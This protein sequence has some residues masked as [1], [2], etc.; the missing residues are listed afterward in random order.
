MS[1]PHLEVAVG[2]ILR[3]D[4]HVL[5]GS[6]PAGKPWEG[7]WEL[8]G[9]KIEAGETVL[10]ALA[11]ELKEELDI[12]V[13]HAEPWVIY[14]HEY[15]KNT[16]R[17][18]FYRIHNWQGEPRGLEGQEIKWVAPRNP[19]T[20]GPLLPAALPPLRW[21]QLPEQ[22]LLT[23]IG[24]AEQLPLY[25]QKL[26]QALQ[27]GLRM[28]QFR[29]P[30]WA[31]QT[32]QNQAIHAAFQQV[33]S[34]C[35]RYQALCLINSVHPEAWWPQADGL[36]LRSN[37]ASPWQSRFSH[38]VS[39]RQGLLAMSTHNEADIQVARALNTDFIVL[40]HVLDTPSHPNVAGM[41]WQQFEQQQQHAACPVYAIGGQSAST[42]AT[43]QAHGAH[44]IA[45]IR[46]LVGQ[47]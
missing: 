17:L 39:Q 44:G 3:H 19:S 33:L 27:S 29:E 45:G 42:L 23:S 1:K 38:D 26:E 32:G 43:A 31:A 6:R 11:R 5:L 35:H 16:V 24:E 7:W 22:Y 46:H 34:L 13:T 30:A 8:P 10:Q 18:H 9:G 41:G 25:L 14:T 21:L 2:V 28:V 37:D 20:S 40:G 15:P 4:G 47:A 12:S 36:H